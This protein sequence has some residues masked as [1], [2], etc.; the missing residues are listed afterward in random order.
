MPQDGLEKLGLSSIIQV[1]KGDYLLFTDADTYH[2]KNM[3]I[4]IMSATIAENA[5]LV[6]MGFRKS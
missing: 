5:G 4:N 1:A 3:L 2:E 6:S